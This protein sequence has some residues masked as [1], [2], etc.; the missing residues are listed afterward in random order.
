[1]SCER[2]RPCLSAI[3]DGEW[4]LVPASTLAHVRACRALPSLTPQGA[5]ADQ[6]GGAPVVTVAYR[7]GAGSPVTLSWLDAT[8]GPPG[9]EDRS[10]AGR[11]VLLVRSPSG[12]AVVAGDAPPSTLRSVAAQLQATRGG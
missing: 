2:H 12:T 4:E 6:V 11:T 1:V 5:R 7:T 8:P 10:A 3:A 9:V